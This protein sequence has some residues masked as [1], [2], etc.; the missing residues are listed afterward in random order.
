[1]V[2][3]WKKPGGDDSPKK[4]RMPDPSKFGGLGRKR[5]GDPPDG[6]PTAPIDARPSPEVEPI[7]PGDPGEASQ[8]EPI[9]VQPASPA[10][11]PVHAEASD[12]P[13]RQSAHEPGPLPEPV[14]AP[15]PVTVD[16]AAVTAELEPIPAAP[17]PAE[18]V[19]DGHDDAPPPTAEASAAPAPRSRW[20]ERR[21]RRRKEP[22]NKRM[23]PSERRAAEAAEAAA[24]AASASSEDPVAPAGP[25]ASTPS[26]ATAASDA[27]GPSAPSRVGKAAKAPWRNKAEKPKR[28]VVVERKPRKRARR[29]INRWSPEVRL[30]AYLATSVVA[31]A[32]FLSLAGMFYLGSKVRADSGCSSCHAMQTYVVAHRSSGHQGVACSAC[33]SRQG[34][35]ATFAE[36]ARMGGW[37]ADSLLGKKPTRVKVSDDGCRRCHRSLLRRTVDGRSVRVRHADFADEDCVSRCHSGVAHKAKGRWYMGPQMGDCLQCHRASAGQM[38]TCEECH[39][40]RLGQAAR[41]QGVSSWRSTHGPG[42]KTTHGAG[43]LQECR[44]C[45]APTDCARCHGIPLPHPEMWPRAHGH[46]LTEKA[47][48]SCKTCHEPGWCR[49]C[50]GVEMPH[51]DGFLPLH[52][53]EADQAGTDACYKCHSQ[54]GCIGCHFQSSHPNVPGVGMHEGLKGVLGR[55]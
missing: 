13:G 51:P 34:F 25:A 41:T 24:R 7:R 19:V 37:Y 28:Q 45:H 1:M 29:S 38:E 22:A 47:R 14:L 20:G 54:R 43:D 40:K 27:P 16:P 26:A 10:E 33:H 42:W 35:L 44:V 48:K 5:K 36:G 23:L 21:P 17:T 49:N 30:F 11:T 15:E 31:A 9:E 52:G 18:E 2:R 8:P 53:A 55:E 46:G 3:E 50:H 4:G 6:A 32:A 12:A 39:P